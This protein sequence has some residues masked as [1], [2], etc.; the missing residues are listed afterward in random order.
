ML[1]YQTEQNASPMQ[2]NTLL[3]LHTIQERLL[4][5]VELFLA[6]A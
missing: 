6:V 2:L 3:D 5:N 4:W 1:K